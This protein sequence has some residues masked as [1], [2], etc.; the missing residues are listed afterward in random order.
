MVQVL[1]ARLFPDHQQPGLLSE[2][3]GRHHQGNQANTLLHEDQALL[4]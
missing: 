2:Q 4:F 1:P 3:P